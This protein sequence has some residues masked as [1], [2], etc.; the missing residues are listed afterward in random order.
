M[1]THPTQSRSVP[2]KPSPWVRGI[3][4]SCREGGSG[5]VP[6]RRHTPRKEAVIGED[7]SVGRD[8]T[9]LVARVLDS[10]RLAPL[11]KLASPATGEDQ[12]SLVT[13]KSVEKDT[14]HILTNGPRSILSVTRMLFLALFFTK[15]CDII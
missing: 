2:A 1:P 4:L 13:P 7:K 15:S 6:D 5:G 9:Q 10:S 14:N 8:Q 12:S 11:G 3:L